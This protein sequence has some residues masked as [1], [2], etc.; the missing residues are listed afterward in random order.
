MGAPLKKIKRN[1]KLV[2]QLYPS[3]KKKI[4]D[5]VEKSAYNNTSD[6]VRDVTL[7]GIYKVVT[8]DNDLINRNDLL[9]QQVRNIGNNFNQLLKNIHSKKLSYFTQEDIKNVTENLNE[10]K[11]IYTKIESYFN[12]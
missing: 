11:D 3:E 12:K 10:I 8:I 2:V 6:F 1:D 7:N 5:I 4:I 9:L